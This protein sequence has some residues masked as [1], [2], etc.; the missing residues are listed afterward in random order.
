MENFSHWGKETKIQVQEEQR[1]LYKMNL[2]RSILRHIVIKMKK[3][4]DEGILKS[5]R[6]IQLHGKSQTKNL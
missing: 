2:K 6:E 4:K 1:V 5:T 3:I